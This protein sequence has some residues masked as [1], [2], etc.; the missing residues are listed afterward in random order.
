MPILLG[1]PLWI[2]ILSY[3]AVSVLLA[4]VRNDFVEAIGEVVNAPARIFEKA[5]EWLVTP[6]RRLG[7]I[8]GFERAVLYAVL[9]L[10]V[11]PP[12]ALMMAARVAALLGVEETAIP[13]GIGILMGLAV[14]FGEVIYLLA[15]LDLAAKEP[16]PPWDDL[17][18]PVVG[19]L[20]RHAL[21]LAIAMAITTGG[22]WLWGAMAVSGIYFDGLGWL[23]TLALG[24]QLAGAAALAF[25]VGRRAFRAV[26]L[27]CLAALGGLFKLLVLL[28]DG[29]AAALTKVIDILEISGR[30]TWNWFC[31]TAV[32]RLL[33]FRPVPD[34]QPRPVIG[35]TRDENP[36]IINQMEDV[37]KVRPRYSVFGCG[38]FGADVALE[39]STADVSF[40][41]FDKDRASIGL[42][43]AKAGLNGAVNVSPQGQMVSRGQAAALEAMFSRAGEVHI[44]K[45]VVHGVST[46]LLDGYE[47]APGLMTKHG[48]RFPD[49]RFLVISELGAD[50]RCPC[51]GTDGCHLHYQSSAPIVHK[52]SNERF[53]SVLA[54]LI[55]GL[56]VAS[57]QY[58]RNLTLGQLIEWLTRETSCYGFRSDSELCAPG[59]LVPVIG[60]IMSRMNAFTPSYGDPLDVNNRARTAFGVA[61]TDDS[62]AAVQQPVDLSRPFAVIFRLPLPPRHPGFASTVRELELDSWLR[63]AYPKAVAV[64]ASGNGVAPGVAI[65]KERWAQC[66]ILYPLTLTEPQMGEPARRRRRATAS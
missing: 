1:I 64:F 23:L 25:A 4:S 63:E 52:L 30:R 42:M 54:S 19:L 12:D 57:E 37:M 44:E 48:Q 41:V 43:A 3:L 38:K 51:P 32:G 56:H 27:G 55:N 9:F 58:E 62:Y 18:E 17:P 26:I 45:E 60:Q 65:E 46:V 61:L 5:S 13:G 50:G 39:I 53:G 36:Q 35:G 24:L 28:L 59:R 29:V 11:G 8:P 22:L 6:Q 33:N 47:A 14:I 20:R 31:G 15:Y 10:L 66:I 2:L 16:S 40:G 21:Q 49:E 7:S 34:R